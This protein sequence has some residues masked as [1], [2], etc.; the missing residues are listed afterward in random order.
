VALV[1]PDGSGKST[2]LAAVRARAR[3]IPGLKIEPAYLGPWGQMDMP[4]VP[5]LRRLGIRPYKDDGAAAG[6]P[7]AWNRALTSVGWSVKGAIF[8]CAT[9]AE[10]L[11]RYIRRV[12]WRTRRGSWVVSDRYI[13]DLR[14]LYKSAP[15]ERHAFWRALVCHLFPKP[16]LF[17]LLD[18]Q[19]E[20]V[21]E[22]KTQLNAG[23]VRTV[24]SLCLDAIRPYP[25]EVIVTDRPPQAI[26]DDVLLRILRLSETR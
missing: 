21:A 7:S 13:T 26:A 12:L 3:Q 15:I 20:V 11:G 1:G 5:A 25:H 17:I 10:L 9:Y 2:V 19:P 18:N 6:Q 14:Y 22:R 24:R 16:D 23:E 8:Y 4:W